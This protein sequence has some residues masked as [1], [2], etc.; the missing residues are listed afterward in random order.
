MF[1]S[2]SSRFI[3]L[4]LSCSS[5]AGQWNAPKQQFLKVF[6]FSH[7]FSERPSGKRPISSRSVHIFGGA[8]ANSQCAQSPNSSRARTPRV[9]ADLSDTDLPLLWSLIFSVSRE[10]SFTK[11]I[12]SWREYSTVSTCL[13]QQKIDRLIVACRGL[14]NCNFF[15]RGDEFLVALKTR[16]LSRIAAYHYVVGKF[17]ILSISFAKFLIGK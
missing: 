1:Y 6:C 11:F 2:Q 9:K 13:L 12:Y 17:Q 8:T 5:F 10:R 3:S 7:F 15:H 4:F 14:P 16:S